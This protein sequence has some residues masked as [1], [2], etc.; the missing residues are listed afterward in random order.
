M[1]TMNGATEI[2]HAH[3][4]SHEPTHRALQ[5]ICAEYIADQRQPLAV[6]R[7]RLREVVEENYYAAG[8][9]LED[10]EDSDVDYGVIIEWEFENA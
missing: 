3:I 2:V 10:I 8:L 7:D 5:E 4:T 1:I 6:Y 9:D